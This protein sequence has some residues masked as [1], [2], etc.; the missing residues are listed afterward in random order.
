MCFY[1]AIYYQERIN[2]LEYKRWDVDIVTVGD[3][4]AETTI[5]QAMWDN[6][7]RDSGSSSITEFETCLRKAV[8]KMIA[9]EPR[10]LFE[11]EYSLKISHITFAF[12]NVKL[13]KLLGKRGA[14]IAEHKTAN[15]A[16]FEK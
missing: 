11:A 8:E 12:D 9:S 6:F 10:V 4:T 15:L 14:S 2:P 13:I 7:Q 5:T 1:L 3:F 16:K